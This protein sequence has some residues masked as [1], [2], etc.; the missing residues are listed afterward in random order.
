[1]S[2]TQPKQKELSF[3]IGKSFS[4]TQNGLCVSVLLNT[5]ATSVTIK[6]GKNHGYA[7]PLNT[8]Y[9]SLKN[10]KKF[11]ETDCPSH[12]NNDCILKRI[13]ALN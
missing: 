5:Q 8:E 13:N 9:Q 10:L 4:L 2:G 1:M 3:V 11:K 6:R 12:A 7:L